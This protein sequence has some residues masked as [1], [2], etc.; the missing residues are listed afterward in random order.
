MP[1]LQ[2][3]AFWAACHGG[4]LRLCGALAARHAQLAADSAPRG[5]PGVEMQLRG[6]QQPA[7]HLRGGQPG[8]A[9]DQRV[10]RG[11][12]GAAVRGGGQRGQAD[13]RGERRRTEVRGPA[14]HL[15]A[16]LP[17]PGLPQA[18]PL[19]VGVRVALRCWRM[20]GPGRTLGGRELLQ[21]DSVQNS[22][23]SSSVYYYGFVG[24]PGLA[25]LSALQEARE[26]APVGGYAGV[27]AGE[28]AT[29]GGARAHHPDQPGPAGRALRL[30]EERAA[31]VPRAHVDRSSSPPAL[32]A[33]ALLMVVAHVRASADSQRLL[34][35]GLQHVGV[36]VAPGVDR[37]VPDDLAPEAVVAHGE[38]HAGAAI[39]AYLPVELH[40]SDV[41]LQQ[42]RAIIGV[43][44]LLLH[45]G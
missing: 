44:V 25:L 28:L 39:L 16:G 26:E 13:R 34:Q 18:V 2:P 6:L 21:A 5:S 32:H 14:Q 20:P 38:V 19:R 4:G 8:R 3:Q 45:L 31:A 27:D 36:A 41:I 29:R 15:H 12:R 37:A 11:Q 30:V 7:E 35:P 24:V 10:R 42:L 17:V 1:R 33:H 22:I 43:D 40:H 9:D 23:S